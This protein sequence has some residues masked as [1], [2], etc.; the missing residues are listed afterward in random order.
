MPGGGAGDHDGPGCSVD[1]ACIAGIDHAVGPDGEMRKTGAFGAG[2][3]SLARHHR[4]AQADG[5]ALGRDQLGDPQRAGTAARRDNRTERERRCPSAE[6]AARRDQAGFAEHRHI[7]EGTVAVAPKRACRQPF[8][9]TPC[10]DH[11][12]RTGI[13]E[14]AGLGE[15]ERDRARQDQ[16]A[17]A[18]ACR[19]IGRPAPPDRMDDAAGACRR[20]AATATASCTSRRTTPAQASTA[21]CRPAPA[22]FQEARPGRRPAVQDDCAPPARCRRRRHRR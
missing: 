17:A 1:P 8:R 7:D 10:R 3:K 20:R 4:T 12:G 13:G 14:H 21:R 9:R 2:R 5:V 16:R 22:G 6:T 18:F 19:A 15:A 11:A